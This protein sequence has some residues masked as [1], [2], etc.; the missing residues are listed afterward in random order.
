MHAAQPPFRFLV[1]V[2]AVAAG[3]SVGNLWIAQPLLPVMAR[4]FATTPH[5]VGLVATLTQVGY[6]LGLM[7]FVPLGD[8]VERRRL[9]LVLLGAVTLA[10]VAVAAAPTLPLLAAGSL[11]V[12]M[13]T[14]VPQL[15]VPLAAPW[16]RSSAPGPG[17][18]PAGRASASPKVRFWSPPWCCGRPALGARR[19]ERSPPLDAPSK[20]TSRQPQPPRCS[21]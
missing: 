1:A 2:L 10:L 12:G 19:R 16:A 14:V 8:V 20:T 15:A 17:R 3:A 18:P 11:A 4:D 5:G 7:L 13:T 9:M 6:G 21:T